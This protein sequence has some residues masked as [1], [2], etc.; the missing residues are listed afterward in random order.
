QAGVE[1]VDG[2]AAGERSLDDLTRFA[3]APERPRRDA[4]RRARARDRDDVVDGQRVA[5]ELDRRSRR[6][7]IRWLPVRRAHRA[8]DAE[9][10]LVDPPTRLL[11]SQPRVTTMR[12][13]RPPACSCAA[14]R[15]SW[16]TL[17]RLRIGT[18]PDRE[19]WFSRRWSVDRAASSPP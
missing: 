18:Q 11:G 4:N 8:G 1:P 2:A 5:R 13:C 15:R 6:A 17:A 10:A 9:P 7:K 16:G 12:R 3:H 19:L 14:T